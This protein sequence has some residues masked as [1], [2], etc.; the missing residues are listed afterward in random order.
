[1]T[2]KIYAI[3]VRKPKGRNHL[4]NLELDERIILKRSERKSI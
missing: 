4:V 3:S 2:I 1:M